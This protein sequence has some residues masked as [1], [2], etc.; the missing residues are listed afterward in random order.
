MPLCRLARGAFLWQSG[1]RD[2]ARHGQHRASWRFPGGRSLN[3]P[4]S[5][6][7]A[8]VREREPVAPLS[9]RILVRPCIR[10]VGV[11]RLARPVPEEIVR[12]TLVNNRWNVHREVG[13]AGLEELARNLREVADLSRYIAAEVHLPAVVAVQELENLASATALDRRLL[14]EPADSPAVAPKLLRYLATFGIRACPHALDLPKEHVRT[15]RRLR[16]LVGLQLLR[17]RDT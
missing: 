7:E 17:V 5:V 14:H 15:E 9:R 2:V 1:N 3:K 4:G 13:G 10:C 16:I 6:V 12:A 8:G 11:Y